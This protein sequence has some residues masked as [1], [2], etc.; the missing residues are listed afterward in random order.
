MP[1]VITT[2]LLEDNPKGL[3][4][5]EIA[6]WI[7]K[8]FVLPRSKL[9]VAKNRTELSAPGIYFLFGKGEKRE[10]VYIG[11]SEDVL[12]R[13]GSHAMTREED[14]W[15]HALVF[16]GGLDNTYIKYLE[17]IAIDQIKKANRYTLLNNATPRENTLSE[18]QKFVA[19]DY[20]ERIKLISAVAGYLPFD[21]PE[22]QINKSDTYYL[23]ADGAEARGKILDTQEFFVEHGAVVRKRET[24][25]LE[26]TFS[27]R[28][29]EQFIKEEKFSELNQE[30][31]QFVEDYLFSS[32]SAAAA[33]IMGRPVNGWTAWK[34][35]NGKTLDENIRK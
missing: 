35:K 3:R 5:F 14:E 10:Q 13:L 33:T 18:S 22:E 31:Y 4:M 19:S 24:S 15:S 1:Q 7:G 12:Y 9:K 32:P 16:I 30:S 17:S 11:Q 8:S 28:L 29:R 34:D 20:F 6:G 21:D 26:G 25:A 2:I 23:K 27:S